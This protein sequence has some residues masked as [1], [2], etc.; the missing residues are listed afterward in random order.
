MNDTW[1]V[2]VTPGGT[3]VP[4]GAHCRIGKVNAAKTR[5]KAIANL[6]Q[7]G[8]HMPYGNDWK[9]WEARGYTIEEWS[10]WEP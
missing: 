10:G 2:P 5:E 6:L 7:D 4:Y 9:V 3:P 1:F 8:A